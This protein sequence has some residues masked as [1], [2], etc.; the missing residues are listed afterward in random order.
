MIHG[1]E[2]LERSLFLHHLKMRWEDW[3]I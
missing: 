2:K 1:V 3:F